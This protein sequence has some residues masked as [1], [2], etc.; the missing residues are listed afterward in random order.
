VLLAISC[1]HHLSE[2][3]KGREKREKKSVQRL[4]ASSPSFLDHLFKK[5]RRFGNSTFLFIPLGKGEAE[6][7]KKEGEE[8]R[9]APSLPRPFKLIICQ[10]RKKGKKKERKKGYGRRLGKQP[11]RCSPPSTILLSI[12]QK[13]KRGKKEKEKRREEL[14][15]SLNFFQLRKKGKKGG[16]EG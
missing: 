14:N 11:E 2:E 5:K 12:P 3:K 9:G 13:K 6:K 4:D 10:K 1:I 16:E 8:K 7:G 15:G